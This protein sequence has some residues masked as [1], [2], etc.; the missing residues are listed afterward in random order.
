MTTSRVPRSS[1]D[2][3]PDGAMI[4]LLEQE[5]A[6]L[7]HAVDSHAAVDQ[8]IGVLTASHQLAPAVGFEVLRE[9]SQHTHTKLQT[10]TETVIAWALWQPLPERR[11]GAV[12]GRAAVLT[13]AGCPRRGSRVGRG[14][15]ARR[16]SGGQ[17]LIDG[18]IA[19]DDLVQADDSKKP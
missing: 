7:R 15:W 4:A 11:A 16:G 3:I 6:Q 10:V 13:P 17:G 18:G 12:R 8:A 14:G 9:V 2:G 19:A 5:N 1:L